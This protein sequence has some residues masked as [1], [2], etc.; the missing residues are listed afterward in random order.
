MPYRKPV[1]VEFRMVR[2]LSGPLKVRFVR[3]PCN[4]RARS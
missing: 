3:T 1:E 2:F 4:A